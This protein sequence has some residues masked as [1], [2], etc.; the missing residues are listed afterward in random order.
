MPPTLSLATHVAGLAVT[1]AVYPAGHRYPF[2]CDAHSRVSIVLGGSLREESCGEDVYAS[3]ASVVVK[4]ADAE[5]RDTFGPEGARLLS[6]V[7]PDG[8]VTDEASAARVLGRWR[9]HHA[10]PVGAAALRFVRSV[11]EGETVEDDLWDLIGAVSETARGASLVPSWLL[12]VRERM[13]D[14]PPQALSVATLAQ[15]AGVHPV[16]LARAFRRA[17]GCSPSAYRRRQRV[18]AAADRLASSD[19]PAALVALDAGF[20]DQSHMCRDLRAEL[21]LSPGRVRALLRTG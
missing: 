15:G 1:D 20:A 13:D 9:W 3:A 4:P 8:W 18:R 10:G 7:A 16:S 21:G 14:E 6:I 12:R 11:R 2:H 19:T 17:F 5:H